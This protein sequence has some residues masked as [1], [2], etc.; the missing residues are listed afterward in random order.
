[1]AERL[2]FPQLDALVSFCAV[3]VGNDTGPK[4]LASVRGAPV[5][6][7]HMGAVN[8]REWGQESGFIVTRRTPCY[9]CGIEQIED[10]G[11]GLP[12]LVNITVE[13][14]FGAVEQALLSNQI[15]GQ[16]AQEHGLVGI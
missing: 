13:D 16:P 9:G 11:K 5:V 2:R 4:H 6:S 1:M 7:V 8:W 3:F 15:P 12:C 14:V 10:C